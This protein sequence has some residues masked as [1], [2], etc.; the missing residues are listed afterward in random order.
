MRLYIAI[1]LAALAALAGVLLGAWWAAFPVCAVL[2]A[3]DRRARIAIPAGL[4]IGLASWLVPLAV[5]NV[6]YGVGPAASA[7][8]AI[9][10]FG[11]QGALPVVLTLLVGTLLG[12]TGAW[13][14]NA[15]RGVVAP[16]ARVDASRSG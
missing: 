3:A 12:G 4:A 11:H 13:L 8:A 2:G 15:A 16:G 6:R 14:G 1:L 7:L 9:M 5:A 10:G